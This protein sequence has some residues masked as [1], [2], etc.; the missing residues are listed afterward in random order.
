MSLLCYT[1][2]GNLAYTVP[3]DQLLKTREIYPLS[4]CDIKRH[5][6]IHNDFVDDDAY[7]LE[8]RNA[9]V[10]MCS[11]YLN[12]AIAKTLNALRID[13]FYSDTLKVYE[14]N[15]LNIISIQD[16]SSVV[17]TTPYQTSNHYDFFTI[18]WDTFVCSDPIYINFYTGFEEDGTPELIKQACLIQISD[19]YDN[20]RSSY[21]WAGMANSK[22]VERILN[23]YI[24]MRW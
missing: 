17:I 23:Q 2:S 3:E 14:G 13:D 6:R 12:K 22:V 19:F 24:A 16:A 20:E 1:S 9:A 7:I 8:L 4:L 15:F 10:Q 18:E 21:N 11:N 5:L